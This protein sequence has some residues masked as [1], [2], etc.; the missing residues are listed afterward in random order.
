M[1]C[2]VNTRNQ[3]EELFFINFPADNKKL[4]DTWWKIC[5]RNDEF[6]FSFKICSIHFNIDDFLTVTVRREGK[7]FKQTILKNNNIVPTRYLLSH[8]YTKFTKKQ[9][10]CIKDSEYNNQIFK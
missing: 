3:F 9:K 5:G 1:L 6:D 2:N 7:L 4:C 8:E 10:R